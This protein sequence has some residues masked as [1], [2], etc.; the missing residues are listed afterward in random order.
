MIRT[1]VDVAQ[2]S[3]PREETDR[4]IERLGKELARWAP[5]NDRD[6]EAGP[7]KAPAGNREG[8]DNNFILLELIMLGVR[9]IR[10]QMKEL[11]ERVDELRE[12][13]EENLA[14]R[15]DNDRTRRTYNDRGPGTTY[16]HTSD[17]IRNRAVSDQEYIRLKEARNLIPDF[18]GTSR[19]RLLEFLS[20]SAFA[21]K[22]INPAEEN[23]L[24]DSIVCTKLKGKAMADFR[25][26]DIKSYEQLRQELEQSYFRKRGGIHLQIKFNSLK[27]GFNENARAFGSRVDKIAMELYES[28]V[29]G[30]S[31]SSIQ[32]RTILETIQGQ[33]LRNYQIG[34][35][36]ED[37]KLLV[38]AQHYA[39]LQEAITGASAEEKVARHYGRK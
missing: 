2:K 37:I 20:A 19:T 8:M 18:D 4:D 16:G 11:R 10:E 32:K 38:R 31:Y 21:M 5:A 1:Q 25:T 23:L 13:G 7:G 39:T 14:S 26:R 24:L 22:Y 3:I 30:R 17:D 35:R 6:G 34:L 27:Q 12:Q 36:S 29:E 15:A 9:E 33:A 28:T